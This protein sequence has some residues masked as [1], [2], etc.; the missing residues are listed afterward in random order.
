MQTKSTFWVGKIEFLLKAILSSEGCRETTTATHTWKWRWLREC[1]DCKKNEGKKRKQ[2]RSHRAQIP[3]A[4]WFLA[5]RLRAGLQQLGM[6]TPGAVGRWALEFSGVCTSHA[7][8]FFSGSTQ[9]WGTLG[10]LHKRRLFVP[11]IATA[12]SLEDNE[13]LLAARAGILAS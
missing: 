6:H 10:R 5:A 3:S 13:P 9:G 4:Q 12:A 1:I 7:I 8:H 11:D 2:K